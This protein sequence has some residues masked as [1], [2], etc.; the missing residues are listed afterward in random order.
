MFRLFPDG[1]REKSRRQP[2]KGK[3]SNRA[4]L[5]DLKV[6]KVRAWFSAAWGL[7]ARSIPSLRP[8]HPSNSFSAHPSPSFPSSSSSFS[9]PLRGRLFYLFFFF[10]CNVSFHLRRA[11]TPIGYIRSDLLPWWFQ[12]RHEHC[13]RLRLTIR[14]D[15][16]PFLFDR[17]SLFPIW[18]PA[19]LPIPPFRLEKPIPNT[20]RITKRKNYSRRM[21]RDSRGV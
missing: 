1:D 17:H 2:H 4:P 19:S 8:L 16:S 14:P 9:P 12:P 3:P 10:F 20:R 21:R 5:K 11:E 6:K 18:D 15:F 7:T 13:R